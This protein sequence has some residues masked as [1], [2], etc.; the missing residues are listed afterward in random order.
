MFKAYEYLQNSDLRRLACKGVLAVN[1]RIND[2]IKNYQS[3]VIFDG[4]GSCGCSNYQVTN[5]AVALVGLGV[6]FRN[7]HCQ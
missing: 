4:D 7:E 5:H 6:D 1:V 3:G 2:C